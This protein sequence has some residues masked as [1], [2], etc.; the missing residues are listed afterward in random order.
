MRH[1]K[2]ITKVAECECCGVKTILRK[3]K[4]PEPRWECDFCS[5]TL[6]K[7]Y[8]PATKQHIAVALHMILERLR[9][10]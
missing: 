4:C 1:V 8:E 6:G 3:Y 7:T 10:K 2:R 5:S 9:N